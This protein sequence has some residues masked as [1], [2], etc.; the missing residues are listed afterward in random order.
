MEQEFSL[1][2]YYTPS[3]KKDIVLSYKGPVTDG[4]IADMG[5]DVRNLFA[6]EKQIKRKIFA[7]FIELAQNILYYSAEKSKY[8]DKQDSLG[9]LLITQT[10]EYYLLSCGNLIENI[11]APS[12][13]DRCCKINSLTREDLRSYKRE[14]RSL[15]RSQK[16]RGAGIGL[17]QVA[18]LSENRLGASFIEVS[19]QFT[20]FTLSIKITR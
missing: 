8:Q 20:Y 18:L 3:H 4:L 10:P 13:L 12:L 7:I 2:D 17:I 15:P 11:D 14:E 6:H 16:S 9:T 1:L 5:Q 19:D